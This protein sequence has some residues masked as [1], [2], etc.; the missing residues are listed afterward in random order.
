MIAA[1]KVG[2]G[3]RRYGQ[4]VERRG[5]IRK[6]DTTWLYTDAICST[7]VLQGYM[8]RHHHADGEKKQKRDEPIIDSRTA[9]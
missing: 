7:G 8:S 5:E 4:H 2:L 1:G 9:Q 3:V 6:R